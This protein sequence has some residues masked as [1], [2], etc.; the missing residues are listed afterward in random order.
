MLTEVEGVRIEIQPAR[1]D[2]GEIQ[3]IIMTMSRA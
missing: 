2:L 3:H 1:F